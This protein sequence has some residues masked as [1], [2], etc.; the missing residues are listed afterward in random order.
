MNVSVRKSLVLVAMVVTQLPLAGLSYGAENKAA[1]RKSPAT[2]DKAAAIP[3]DPICNFDFMNY[4]YS[5]S[6]HT[7][8][9]TGV[10]PEV[11]L[12]NGEASLVSSAGNKID[13]GITK[14]VYGELTGDNAYEAVV[15][16]STIIVG[17]EYGTDDLYVFRYVS[18]TPVLLGLISEYDMDSAFLNYFPGGVLS[19][20]LTGIRIHDRALEVEKNVETAVNEPK[21]NVRITYRY[22]N[23]KLSVTGMPVKVPYRPFP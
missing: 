17:T 10:P 19:H 21:Y 2:V 3:E 13:M 8:K 20:G 6:E 18:G 23:G 12:R 22:E 1:K 9:T 4:K 15:R 16:M 5:I 11:G 7:L 14:I